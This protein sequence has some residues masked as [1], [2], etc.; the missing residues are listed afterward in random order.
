MVSVVGGMDGGSEVT[1]GPEAIRLPGEEQRCTAPDA[2]S[3]LIAVLELAADGALRYSAESRRPL[4][5]TVKL[6]DDALVAGDFHDGAGSEAGPVAAYA[7]PLLIHVGGLARL[8]DTTLR[9]TVA[10]E[11]ALDEPAYTYLGALWRKWLGNV[12]HDEFARIDVI[13]GQRRP[14]TLTSAPGRRV[15]VAAAL[16]RASAGEWTDTVSLLES[17]RTG[18]PPLVVTRNFR[19]LWRLY[20]GDAYHG[21][22]GHAAGRAWDIIETR[23]ALCFLFEY[24][25]TLGLIDVRYRDPAGARDDYRAL[26]GAGELPWLSRY[27]GLHAVRVNTLGAAILRDR[28]ADPDSVGLPRPRRLSSVRYG[29]SLPVMGGPLDL[30][31]ERPSVVRAGDLGDPLL[32]GHQHI[33]ASAVLPGHRAGGI[34]AERLGRAHVE[35]V[36]LTG[37]LAQRGEHLRVGERL[38]LVLLRERRQV[39]HP[40]T[41]GVADVQRARA[42]DEPEPGAP[43]GS[44]RGQHPDRVLELYPVLGGQR[45]DGDHQ[46]VRLCGKFLDQF[47]V[48]QRPLPPARAAAAAD[49]D[50]RVPAAGRL[51]ADCAA[52]VP[53]SA[54][55]SDFCHFSHLSSIFVYQ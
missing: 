51:G 12:T 20:I 7:W 41:A 1:V 6:V 16:A 8:A 19:A 9:L 44:R 36:H 34:R 30:V 47:P 43:L 2:L 17:I 38:A 14:G 29:E 11:N 54:E 3:N 24:A 35:P 13:K 55:N 26:W 15:A 40:G 49:R 32:V 27:D 4:A 28:D 37:G 22:L 23:Y 25:A 53:G 45:P 33:A 18:T 5:A 10:G 48:V 50:H 39:H 21:T 52:R 42:A 46:H 31:N